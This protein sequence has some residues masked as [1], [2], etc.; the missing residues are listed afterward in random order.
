MGIPRAKYE[1][2]IGWSKAN[3]FTI[4]LVLALINIGVVYLQ[5]REPSTTDLEQN[6][7]VAVLSIST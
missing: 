2:L 5:T 6:R 1:T 7:L 3:K 4:A